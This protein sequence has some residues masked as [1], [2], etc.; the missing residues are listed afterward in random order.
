MATMLETIGSFILVSKDMIFSTVT[1][2]MLNTDFDTKYNMI[3]LI[4]IREPRSIL[5]VYDV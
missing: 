2:T 1:I 4:N 5:H 3:I